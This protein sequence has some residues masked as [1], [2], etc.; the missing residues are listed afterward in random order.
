MPARS[1]SPLVCSAS[2][3]SSAKTL[4]KSCLTIVTAKSPFGSSTRSAF[5]YSMAS[6][7]YASASASRP[8]PSALPASP[9]NNVAWPIRS[10]A[11]FA[12]AMSS[13][14][15]GAC[16]HHSDRRWPSTSRSS[17]RR[18]KYSLNFDATGHLVELRMPIGFV[19]PRIEE[20]AHVLGR[21]RRNLSRAD[22]PDAHGFA[23]PR[24]DVACVLQRRLRVDGVHT[25]R[26][27]VRLTTRWLYEDLPQRPLRVAR[28]TGR[29]VRH[30][31]HKKAAP[32]GRLGRGT[33][34]CLFRRVRGRRDT[35]PFPGGVRIAP[36]RESLAIARPVALH[37]T[38][39]L[40]PIDRTDLPVL[41]RLVIRELGIGNRE[42]D[43]LGLRDREIDETLTK[44]VVALSLHAPSHQLVAV[45]GFA[46]V[47]AEHHERWPPPPIERVLRHAPL[48]RRSSRE[49]HHDLVALPLVE[50]LFL[51]DPHHRAGIRPIRRLREHRLID[52]RRAVDQ[53][54]NG[55]DVRPRQRRIIENA[56][57][58]GRSIEQLL[59]KFLA[60]DA[61]RLRSA[62]DVEAVAGFV[63]YLGQERHLPSERRRAR[64]PVPLGQHAHDL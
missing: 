6:R 53:P 19:V 16:P 46:V 40:I 51:A 9:S 7:R 17:P 22:D 43:R 32:L 3:C 23:P 13:S 20:R 64:D 14:R 58:L 31:C 21:R 55:A 25:A 49:R 48:R 15:I 11:M 39:D 18:S 47:R 27:L 42:V 56:R 28:R 36:R 52:D 41:R 8:F 37:D 12:R 34:S 45:G 57:V 63:L 29:F 50:V 5:R 44:L 38:P 54:T 62:V 2:A 61:E 59:N 1:R 4:K 30:R 35:N 33:G 24:V 60:I 10:R 26:V